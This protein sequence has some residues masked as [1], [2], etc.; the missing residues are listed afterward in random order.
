MDYSQG[1]DDEGD[2]EDDGD[3]VPQTKL[4]LVNEP[5]LQ[6]ACPWFSYY[7]LINV[8][9]REVSIHAYKFNTYI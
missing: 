7:W 3:E 2:F 9:R 1:K 8:L 5:D 4:L 6:S